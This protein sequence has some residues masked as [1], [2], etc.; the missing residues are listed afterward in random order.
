MCY[1]VKRRLKHEQSNSDCVV[2]PSSSSSFFMPFPAVDPS[3]SG[4]SAC[5]CICPLM[6]HLSDLGLVMGPLSHVH[7]LLLSE[8]QKASLFKF[9]GSEYGGGCSWGKMCITHSSSPTCVLGNLQFYNWTLCADL[10]CL[11]VCNIGTIAKYF[12]SSC[13]YRLGECSGEISR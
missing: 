8:N 5:A 2:C 4:V 7:S 1:Q 13:M 11:G 10:C 9:S 12:L 3:T 6:W